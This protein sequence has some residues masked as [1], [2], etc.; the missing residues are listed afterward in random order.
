MTELQ[1]YEYTFK[2]EDSTR[3]QLADLLTYR[4]HEKEIKVP[5]I[6]ASPPPPKVFSRA[7]TLFFDG[8]CRKGSQKAGGGLVLVNLEGEIEM[9]E[10]VI[11]P[12]SLSNNKAKYDI[13]ILGLE[14]CAKKGIKKLMVKGDALL[15]VE[16]VLDIWACK[17]EKLRAKVKTVSNLLSQFD[18]TQLHHISRKENQEANTLAQ[19]SVEGKMEGE[20]MIMAATLKSPKF[21]GME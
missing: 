6:K 18:E 7:H 15:V 1:E 13:L 5:N 20:V 10:Y 19:R 9:E 12:K 4:L 14:A 21:E 17:G 8:A 11:L 16:Q 2:V 3:A